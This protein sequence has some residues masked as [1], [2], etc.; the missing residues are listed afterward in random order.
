MKYLILS[1]PLIPVIPPKLVLYVWSKRF[2]PMVPS[3]W[4]VWKGRGEKF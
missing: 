4:P 3:D 2:P 1:Y